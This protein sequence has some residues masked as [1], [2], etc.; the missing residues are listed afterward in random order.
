M[1]RR[2][3][4]VLI[5]GGGAAGITAALA[6]ARRSIPVVV[7]EGG[8]Y[9][10][11]ENW[12]GAV[13]FCENLVRPDVL[14]EDLL[15]QT[16]MER[17]IV[18]RGLLLC[19][20]NIALGGSVRSGEAFSNCYTVLRPVFDHDLAE[21]ARLLGAEIL[22]GTQVLALI[23]ENDAVKG[24][25]TDR[26]PIWADVVFLAEGD[27]SNL[28]SR[29]G[30]ETI[31]PGDD[32]LARPEFLQGIK[33]VL[34]LPASSI[35]SRFGVQ[36]GEGACFEMLL[37]N[38][39][40]DGITVPLNAGAFLYTN[41]D[42][43]SLGIVAPL[44]N[45]QEARV[46]HNR[47]MEWLKGLDPLQE[48]LA[49][50][51]PVS[52]GAKLIRGGGWRQMPR[53]AADGLAV[54]GAAS[55]IGVD[56]P[57]PNYTG[58][59]TFMGYAFA[60][61]VQAIE[62]DGGKYSR[63]AIE[64]HYVRRVQESSYLEDVTW[65]GDWPEFVASSRAFFGE[66][67]DRIAGAADA[68]TDPALGRRLRMKRC[69]QRVAGSTPIKEEMREA[70]QAL[71]LME[72]W[73]ADILYAL[74][75]WTLNLFIGWWP[76]KSKTGAEFV[77]H[78]W[79]ASDAPRRAR[80]PWTWRYAR[81]LLAPGFG[82]ALHHLYRNDG[83]RLRD[84]MPLMRRAILSRMSWVD[85]VLLPL[86]VSWI[87]LR[88][89]CAG[90]EERERSELALDAIQERIDH[91][92]KLSWITY[93][94]DE[95]THIR[96]QSAYDA[97]G[98][99]DNASSSLFHV[100]PAN[101]YEAET[102][103]AQRASVTVLHE[104]CIR[105]ETCWRAD[106]ARVDWGRTR[107]HKLVF[108]SYTAADAWLR[109]SREA[110]GLADAGRALR[111]QEPGDGPES[112]EGA[113]SPTGPQVLVEPGLARDLENVLDRTVK[114]AR[115]FRALYAHL[116]PVLTGSDNAHLSALGLAVVEGVDAMVK[117]LIPSRIDP[118]V[119]RGR[120]LVSW[121]RLART[122]V[123]VRRWFWFEADLE[124][125]FVHHL[126]DLERVTEIGVPPPA[127]A[128]RSGAGARR[129]ALRGLLEDR[130]DRDV[131]NA[132]ED[133]GQPTA[134]ARR[135]LL[136]L[137]AA[138]REPSGRP[139]RPGSAARDAALEEVAR[140]SPALAATFAGHLAVLDL[141][142]ADDLA[143]D[144]PAAL[145]EVRDD[146]ATGRVLGGILRGDFMLD[147][148]GRISG[149]APAALLGGLGLL[150]MPTGDGFCIFAPADST[151]TAEITG[152]I[153]LRGAG[154]GRLEL[155]EAF[156]RA[157]FTGEAAGNWLR[158]RAAWDIV[159]IARG[160]AHYLAERAY[161][162]AASRIQFPGMFKDIRGRDT[163]AK[164]GAVQAMLAGI[165]EG[166]E[167]LEA[168]RGRVG[169]GRAAAA[170]AVDLLGPSP[171]SVSY[172]TGQV[173]GGT[174][175]SEE[176]LVCRFYR[177]AA[178]LTRLPFKIA[179]A[180]QEHGQRVLET[181]HPGHAR[182]PDLDLEMRDVGPGP[183]TSKLIALSLSIAD[184]AIKGLTRSVRDVPTED[185]AALVRDLGRIA[186]L[187]SGLRA[188]TARVEN[189]LSRGDPDA[190]PVGALESYAN[191]LARKA[192]RFAERAR[193]VGELVSLGRRLLDGAA[194]E[195]PT[196]AQG[197][198]YA[199][200]LADGSAF[201]SGDGFLRPPD[202]DGLALTPEL[203][204][205]D[206]AL[207]TLQREMADL[208]ETRFRGHTFGGRP[209]TRHVEALHHVPL[210]DIQTMIAEGRFRVVIPK[211]HG[212]QG[213]KKAAYYVQCTEMMR[214]GDPTQ[215][216]IVMGSAS[217]GTT[218]ILIGIERD[219]PEI[220]RAL[221]ELVAA[222]DEIDAVGGLVAEVLPMPET[223]F[224]AAMDDAMEQLGSLHAAMKSK[225]KR[226]VLPGVHRALSAVDRTQK[227][228]DKDGFE[229]ALRGLVQALA[230]WE[231]K[232]RTEVL[233]VPHREA[234]HGFFLELIARGSIS[235][236]A[237][238]EP[239]AGSDTARIRTRA[240]A[241]E[242]PVERDER[243]FWTFHPDGE[244][245]DQ[246][247]NLFTYDTLE[248]KDG[249][250]HFI[251]PDRNRVQVQL[252]DFDPTAEARAQDDGKHRYVEID[253]ERIDIHDIGR[254][255]E[256]DDGAVYPYF[257]VNGAKMWITNGSTAGVMVLYAR[258]PRGPTGFML[259]AHAEGL[260]VG[261][262]EEK[263][264]QCGSATNE[265]A[266]SDVR[267]PRD[268]IIGIEGR[269][270]ENALE[271][272]NVGRAGLS[273]CTTGIML[274]LVDEIRAG[275][276]E[277]DACDLLDLGKIALDLVASES[278]AWQLVGR[279]DHPGTESAR[280]ESAVA[281]AHN[282]EA[283]HRM[284]TRAER[285]LPSAYVLDRHE[286]EKRRRDARVLTIY[287]G[288]S[289]IQRYLLLRDIIDVL[290]LDRL[291][292]GTSG[293]EELDA[294]RKGL[295]RFVREVRDE[296]G[297]RAWQEV[298]L[299]PV[300]AWLV[301]ALIRTEVL[302]ASVQRLLVALRLCEGE[303]GADRRAWL[304]DATRLLARE[305]DRMDLLAWKPFE[306]E[307]RRVRS[308]ADPS[309]SALADRAL[310][311]HE[312]RSEP[313]RPLPATKLGDRPLRI[314]VVIDPRPI[315][316]PRPRLAGGRLREH[317]YELSSCDRGLLREIV[318]LREGE[319][320]VLI[321]V[322]GVGRVGSLDVVQETLALG[323][324][325]GFLLNTGTH[326]LLA[327]EVAGA[328]TDLISLRAE[329]SDGPFDLVAGAGGNAALM[330]TLARRLDL[331]PL[332]GVTAFGVT[333]DGDRVRTT[334]S[335][336][337]GDDVTLDGPAVLLVDAEAQA[338]EFTWSTD[339]WRDARD[340]AV[341]V[342]D[343]TP[344]GRP[345]ATLSAVADESDDGD[346][347]GAVDGAVEVSDAARIFADAME[348]DGT[349]VGGPFVGEFGREP[350]T[351]FLA[352]LGAVAVVEVEPGEGAPGLRPAVAAAASVA[353]ARSAP[354]GVL[355]IVASQDDEALRAAAGDAR[356]VAP[357][358][359]VGILGWNELAERSELTRAHLIEGLMGDRSLPAIFGPELRT[360]AL[361]AGAGRCVA[362][363][364]VL[365]VD[366]VDGL[367]LS[368]GSCTL[369]G[370]RF[371]RKVRFRLDA[372]IEGDPW[373]A[374]VASDFAGVSRDADV[375]DGADARTVLLDDVPLPDREDTLAHV[376]RQAERQ[377][378]VS[379][380][381]A[382]FIIDV[383]YGVGSSDGIEEVID[384]L[385]TALERLG[386]KRVVIGATRKV[387][388]DLGILPDACQIGQT[389]V[390]VNPRV[391]LCVGVSGAPQHLEYI[392]TRAVIFAF[393]RDPDAPLMT[394]NHIRA[395]PVVY[396]IL[397]D[398]FEE[399]P[400]FVAALDQVTSAST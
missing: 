5:V 285:V 298:V 275:L 254:V 62:E 245:E 99:P 262:D 371:D 114:H 352:D 212:G 251:R 321:T 247:R 353:A 201:T 121:I 77:P 153:G 46:P 137:A 14:G 391:M 10:G 35:E 187:A 228:G 216:I 90:P 386:V 81:W 37:R 140:G 54:G 47:L 320:D 48:L 199:D 1:S 396:P 154:P 120:A 155:D 88:A 144:P 329:L 26:G 344:E 267:I 44:G 398:L 104:N 78:F 150:L 332:D 232:V 91:D 235:A 286:L 323:A 359:H 125:L 253:G 169:S 214:R 361:I 394:L 256:R 148:D 93:R 368:N 191:R 240:E 61:A 49:D 32:G 301:D 326:N 8:I 376:V 25:L 74:G 309:T 358:A 304:S 231:Q 151:V 184:D 343:F 292:T 190:T 289:E 317:G 241:R 202:P 300:M 80:L 13:Y 270:Q 288:T 283:L 42:S 266:L 163:I 133:E 219:L 40:I 374:I 325:H 51:K 220:S 57:C 207:G 113:S 36:E 53:L 209:Y 243:G 9:P 75:W 295:A 399:V 28:V 170:L 157:F 7:V 100:C 339:G 244:P 167:V 45:L 142:F 338:S 310:L 66:Q 364:R 355:L 280:V 115:T 21:K 17:R 29:E 164:F 194:V 297:G 380:P 287:E 330:L 131:V 149:V 395:R 34:E 22:S 351:T 64:A 385:R 92:A 111:D 282:T 290:D 183:R 360:A 334:A 145:T 291:E 70:T 27:A 365:I 43:V 276:T 223:G 284:I 307:R 160:M 33:E 118:L 20:G 208:W 366:D 265:L 103:S 39:T 136:E 273:V 188:L 217:I 178:A 24:V 268:Q 311:R 84:K 158:V 350:V 82:E 2:D 193:D 122:H 138:L 185:R 86:A 238:T 225:A 224:A 230:G 377:L 19:D 73:K 3:T 89:W 71:G 30:L 370:L 296:L 98:L 390:P 259:D 204:E 129:V 205:S 206:P 306:A 302:G 79:E 260:V 357:A 294:A 226:L 341:P 189:L 316:A 180:W 354:L 102:D 139:V 381:E 318:R 172:L 50:A 210:D 101:V 175:F 63:D 166:V 38:P 162:H 342:I 234:A 248:F 69:A 389:G 23:R 272:L 179:D 400:R 255:D 143:S 274:D 31:E 67:V 313:A 215:A 379:L 123:A 203:M 319:G 134:D 171:R 221:A 388:Q 173:L 213:E 333:V 305:A 141:V 382:E 16:P 308:G 96:F 218:P 269:G 328:V 315:V 65:L 4:K 367:E 222:K 236:F 392:G 375:A 195:G 258:T 85:V 369:T 105:C 116:P 124:L 97:A 336:A 322:I 176:D 94:S 76:R 257:R 15:A 58:P 242:A 107:G 197:T 293:T 128:D 261:K 314:A 250:L 130:L 327:P 362:D 135:A 112:D 349:D 347:R 192:S 249:G 299:Q 281:K 60:Q 198:T 119:T 18:Q 331:V 41:R 127:L 83:T 87:R 95:R 233:T 174:A 156:P 11:A 263:M 146:L 186:L 52:F 147:E 345:E 126:Q 109:E 356:A 200:Y 59:A 152:A 372:Q 246:R 132:C 303:T 387:T 383:G 177:D 110:A 6:L 117:L 196:G 264:G 237:L 279:F 108:E 12:S 393:N 161:D 312:A 335:R 165:T 378:G 340:Q 229:A 346:S 56:F 277:P 227:K 182:L 106:D 278:I 337:T 239:S 159:A 211:E 363:Q 68:I 181:L 168:L 55:G 348:L 271:T 397:G 252:R 72:G 384:P 324:N 373:Q